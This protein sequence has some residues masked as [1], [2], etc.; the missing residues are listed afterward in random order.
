MKWRWRWRWRPKKPVAPPVPH[1]S[2]NPPGHTCGL[3][4]CNQDD[5]D[6]QL[7][8]NPAPA[9]R[10][11][12]TVPIIS[13]AE[14]SESNFTMRRRRGIDTVRPLSGGFFSERKR[15]NRLLRRN[16][17]GAIV[18]DSSDDGWVTAS[19]DE[20]CDDDD[21]GGGEAD[22]SATLLRNPPKQSPGES[23]RPRSLRF[24]RDTSILAPE[25]CPEMAGVRRDEVWMETPTLLRHRKENRLEPWE[26]VR[27][28]RI[29]LP[30]TPHMA[31]S[32][33][34]LNHQP[35][36]TSDFIETLQR[37]KERQKEEETCNGMDEDDRKL[38]R[39][40]LQF[41]HWDGV[42]GYSSGTL[43][44]ART[45]VNGCRR[46]EEQD[47]ED[48]TKN[49]VTEEN[50]DGGETSKVKTKAMKSK[51]CAVKKSLGISTSAIDTETCT[52]NNGA[53]LNADTGNS[54]KLKSPT[55]SLDSQASRHGV[56]RREANSQLPPV[57]LL[58]A[59]SSHCGSPPTSPSVDC[60]SAT[61][62]NDFIIEE[63]V[64]SLAE[65]SS[66][67]D[68]HVYDVPSDVRARASEVF[69]GDS[70]NADVTSVNSGLRETDDPRFSRNDQATKKDDLDDAFPHIASDVSL[71]D[72]TSL[73]Y[74]F[75][76]GRTYR[77]T[78]NI[79]HYA[80]G[81]NNTDSYIY[82]GSLLSVVS[83]DSDA[84][85]ALYYDQQKPLFGTGRKLNDNPAAILR[86]RLK[87]V[88]GS[89]YGRPI[90]FMMGGKPI[91]FP[92]TTESEPNE[93]AKTTTSCD[94][95]GLCLGEKSGLSS[96]GFQPQP[97]TMTVEDCTPAGFD[98][99][100]DEDVTSPPMYEIGS[101]CPGFNHSELVNLDPSTKL[102]LW[103]LRLICLNR[104]ENQYSTY[105]PRR[106][107][108]DDRGVG[109]TDAARC[110]YEA[111][112]SSGATE[113]SS[114]RSGR[115]FRHRSDVSTDQ[116]ISRKI[117]RLLRAPVLTRADLPPAPGEDK[118]LESRPDQEDHCVSA[119]KDLE[120]SVPDCP[121]DG[122]R[123]LYN[124]FLD[125]DE[126]QT[127]VLPD[128]GGASFASGRNNNL[129][130]ITTKPQVPLCLNPYRS[131]TRHE[132]RASYLLSSDIT[133]NSQDHVPLDGWRSFFTDKISRANHWPG[134]GSDEDAIFSGTPKPLPVDWPFGLESNSRKSG[135]GSGDE[136]DDSVYVYKPLGLSGMYK[137]GRGRAGPGSSSSN[138]SG[139]GDD[140]SDSYN[141]QQ[142]QQRQHHHHYKKRRNRR[143]THHHHHR[144]RLSPL[145]DSSHVDSLL[146]RKKSLAAQQ[147]SNNN[148]GDVPAS[149]ADE[150]STTYD[151]SSIYN[152]SIRSGGSSSVY[153][154]GASN[155]SSSTSPGNYRKDKN[156][157]SNSNNNN[158]V[159]PIAGGSSSGGGGSSSDSNNKV[160]LGP[161]IL[162]VP[163][164]PGPGKGTKKIGNS[165]TD[166][167]GKQV[168]WGD[169]SIVDWRRQA[170]KFRDN[171]FI[172][173]IL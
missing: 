112:I 42:E 33:M 167:K 13:P 51:K 145:N 138:I 157:N 128:E 36:E 147:N 11:C 79:T 105:P 110:L 19:A 49:L 71:F 9:Q 48:Q 84:S 119:E 170:E 89:I 135:T 149:D 59:G 168:I 82:N 55:H 123:S 121:T 61:D 54:S 92:E 162:N 93:A 114:K 107:T 169:A 76:K 118:A 150:D 14:L 127:S 120:L 130:E 40:P 75:F 77:N 52:S 72:T 6:Q 16:S 68:D 100:M 12:V 165:L 116:Y 124:F 70:T 88:D 148:G 143:N 142:Q 39:F 38:D 74:N 69:P 7:S 1:F 2:H 86:N 132:S 30:D 159:S 96:E 29:A 10:G 166:S 27:R 115:V 83:S 126:L 46:R 131:L 64:E 99:S 111:T 125:E 95:S 129:S 91:V 15:K 152:A 137:W 34:F 158:N 23:S 108:L 171:N 3:P 20:D 60:K 25:P 50:K 160:G 136:T 21:D 146:V 73:T 44:S 32:V 101:C 28:R 106:P 47:E 85:S 56:K 63:D 173:L 117:D 163:A 31:H 58:E 156:I 134:F 41:G 53:T 172:T 45:I 140:V 65:A 161:Q 154:G 153:Y 155:I 151:S 22:D 104:E 67:Y 26:A 81:N 5:Q 122:L 109:P 18:N 66:L 94:P 57:P 43:P 35:G 139:S 24:T 8:L 62:N 164:G 4:C 17:D 90:I 133:A 87:T 113:I 102:K 97:L 80:A 103:D 78:N 37:N 144:S 141:Q 98:N